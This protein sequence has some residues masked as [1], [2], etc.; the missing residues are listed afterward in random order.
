MVFLGCVIYFDFA[1]PQKHAGFLLLDLLIAVLIAGLALSMAMKFP[2]T[3]VGFWR[4]V[5]TQ[6]YADVTTNKVKM[7]LAKDFSTIFVPP[8]PILK[9]LDT[10]LTTTASATADEHAET[11]EVTQEKD[12]QSQEKNE[13]K[14]ADETK[15]NA[16]KK[17]VKKDFF[18]LLTTDNIFNYC[19]FINTNPLE[20]LSIRKPRVT[21]V[22]YKLEKESN[23]SLDKQANSNPPEKEALY[24][25]FR[26]QTDNRQGIGDEVDFTKLAKNKVKVLTNIKSLSITLEYLVKQEKNNAGPQQPSPTVS[27][28]ET[29]IQNT[30]QAASL[31]TQT[32]NNSEKNEDTFV[33]KITS[34]WPPATQNNEEKEKLA[35]DVFPHKLIF[36]CK[37]STTS[38][39]Q[40][41]M[42]PTSYKL[43]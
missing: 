22:F 10:D 15:K 1:M 7:L 18:R 3:L 36:D 11:K 37:L 33:V 26:Y 9:Q 42:L 39:H 41:F 40:E 17:K 34:N 29:G 38:L 5:S 23:P 31:P 20:T 43:K 12:E 32:S 30:T 35:K 25:L 21:G 24:T 16:N 4:K 14:N 28:T 27:S 8:I 13:S 19:F 2:V 6:T